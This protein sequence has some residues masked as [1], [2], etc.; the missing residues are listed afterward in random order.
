MISGATYREGL[1]LTS[2]GAVYVVGVASTAVVPTVATVTGS[3]AK[4]R[5]GLKVDSDGRL[6]VRYV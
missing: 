5:G 1:A 3:G 4:T 6:Y 2:D